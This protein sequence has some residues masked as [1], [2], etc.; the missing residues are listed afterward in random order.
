LDT[1][2]DSSSSQ[3][4]DAVEAHLVREA[5]WMAAEGKVIL[6]LG[7]RLCGTVE[8]VSAPT[9]PDQRASLRVR[10][11][12]LILPD[13]NRYEVRGRL[14]E[15]ENARESVAADGTVSGVLTSELPLTMLEAALERVKARDPDLGEEAERRKQREF[16]TADTAIALPA[17]T[18]LQWVL[19]EPLEL[20]ARFDSAVLQSLGEEVSKAV[21]LLLESAPRRARS[22]ERKPGDPVNLA[23]VGSAEDLRAAFQAAGW[24]EAEPSSPQSVWDTVRAVITGRGHTTA[25]M[26]PLYLYGRAE[27]LSFQKMFNTFAKRHHLRLWRSPART[28]DDREIWLA[29]ATHDVGWDIRPDL[30]SHAIDPEIDRE[31]EKVAADLIAAGTVAATALTS[32]LSPLSSGTT[33]TGAPWRTDGLVRVVE[34]RGR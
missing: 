8:E 21:A 6:V 10:F 28:L 2:L 13:G 11:N 15:V 4:G 34:L 1:P 25:P 20:E 14:L 23:L 30:V 27:D 16:G 29:A 9:R 19:E 5:P 18:D 32:P 17:G 33:A 31:R 26:S 12:E 3:P 22:R 7:S 24:S